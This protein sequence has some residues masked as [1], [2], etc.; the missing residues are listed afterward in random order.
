MYEDISF[1][2]PSRPDIP[3]LKDFSLSIKAG[4]KV[5]LVGSSGCGKSTAVGLLE[6]Y[7]D[8]HNGTISIDNRNTKE[9]NIKWLRSIIGFVSQEPVLFSRSIKENIAYGCK[10]KV[11]EKDLEDAAV[12]A[13]IHS[14]V[15]S[16]PLVR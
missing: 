4:Q 16:L 8:P 1:N 2:Y 13:N 15:S 10:G 7:Y 6:R 3:V 12:K 5:A 11:S 9:F 14:F